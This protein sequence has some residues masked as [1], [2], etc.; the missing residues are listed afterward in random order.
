M[1]K[2]LTV[3]LT[4]LFVV[5]ASAA[6]AG[7]YGAAGCGL[8]SVIF[9]DQAGPVQIVA[10]TTNGICGNQTFGITSGTL[11]CGSPLFASNTKTNEFVAANMDALARDIAQGKGETLDAFAELLQ[12]PAA[13]RTAFAG[14]LQANFTQVFASD[15]VVMASVIDNAVAVAN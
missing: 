6:F 9:K 11:N 1:K 14:K 13:E 3:A 2:L 8:G 7:G 4:G 12:V 10:A 15:Q 5:S